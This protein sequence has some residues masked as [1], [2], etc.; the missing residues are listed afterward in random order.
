[1]A[2]LREIKPVLVV[3]NFALVTRFADVQ[4]VLARDDVFQVTY[5][6]K[7]EAVTG[8]PNFF[9]GMQNSPEYVR[10]TA[11]MRTVIVRHKVGKIATFVGNTAEELVAAAGGQIDVVQLSRTVPVRWVDSYFG[12]PAKSETD[13][14][15]WATV[16]FQYLFADLNNDP[17]LDA[18]ALQAAAK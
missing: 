14:A 1:F 18:A 5:G 7:M 4:E 8:G 2:I 9:L 10:D 15:D 13:L 3:K 12:C 17:V 6:E 16:I 11:H